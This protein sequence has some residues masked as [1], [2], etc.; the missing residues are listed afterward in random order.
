MITKILRVE[1]KYTR[2]AAEAVERLI[3]AVRGVK[4]VSADFDQEEV[5]V[6]YDAELTSLAQL[7][8]MLSNVG[9]E[10]EEAEEVR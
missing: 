4:S 8:Y 7:K 6:E 10:S 9:Y 3:G 1:G 2:S 5:V